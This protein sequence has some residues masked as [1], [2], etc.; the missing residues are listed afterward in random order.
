[1]LNMALHFGGDNYWTKLI[2]ALNLTYLSRV[3]YYSE[4]KF[5]EP[6]KSEESEK[7]FSKPLKSEEFGLLNMFFYI[8]SLYKTGFYDNLYNE[9]AI[10]KFLRRNSK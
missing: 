4:K 8:R 1:M 7:K 9:F 6:L 2:L 10:P 5:R 3:I